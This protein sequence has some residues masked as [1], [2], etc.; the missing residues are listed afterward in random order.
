MAVRKRRSCWARRRPI[1]GGSRSPSVI[2]AMRAMQSSASTRKLPT[3]RS[4]MSRSANGT[5]SD[6]SVWPS[7]RQLIRERQIDIVHAH[8]YKTDALAYALAKVE[9]VVPLSTVHGWTGDSPRERLVYYPI[10]R[11]LL[12][13]FPF[14]IAVSTTIRSA[15]VEPVPSRRTSPSC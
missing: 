11:F 2:C 14:L 8:D 3:C 9:K 15:L 7:L 1:R 12:A 6:R 13:R 10:D 5:R 4:T